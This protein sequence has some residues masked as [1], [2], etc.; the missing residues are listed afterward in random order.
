M[1]RAYCCRMRVSSIKN[2]L[3]ASAARKLAH[4]HISS[5]PAAV[6]V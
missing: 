4:H 5:V 3:I 2:M 1:V 6:F